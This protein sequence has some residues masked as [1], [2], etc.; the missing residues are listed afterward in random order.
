[1]KWEEVGDFRCSV[2]RTLSIVG[3]RW[4]LLIVRDAFLG[5]RRF[6]DIQRDLGI[7]RHL[8]S[9]RLRKLVDHEI[10]ERIAYQDKP[11]RY[12]YRLTEKGIDLYP[13]MLTLVDWGDRWMGDEHGPPVEYLHRGCNQTVMPTLHCPDC[14]EKVGA[15]D[16][17]PR[18]KPPFQ[19]GAR[20]AVSGDGAENAKGQD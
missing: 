7:T 13:I 2:A 11:V 20:D 8:L 16:I 12:E 6:D 15:R 10:L 4:T 18:A 3:D 9:E 19:M 1:M 17:K 14:G 5:L